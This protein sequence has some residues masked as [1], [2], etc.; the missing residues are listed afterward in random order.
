MITLHDLN[1]Q[2]GSKI[3]LEGAQLRLHD[4]HRAGLIGAN[5][6]G[7]STLFKLLTGQLAP[8]QGE[9][10]I[11][12]GWRIAHMAQEIEHSDRR[13]LDYV[14]DGDERFREVQ[15]AI[16]SCDGDGDLLARHYAD[17]EAIDGYTAEAR[18]QELLYGLGFGGGDGDRPVADF[19]GGWRI[20]LNLARALMCPA[21]LLL[22][23]EPTNHLDL[24]TTWWLEQRLKQFRG[25][26][27]VISH[28]RDFLDNTVE[29]I[30]H[31]D[32]QRL[33]LYSGSYSD[34]ERQRSER[35][36]QQQQMFEK[37]QAQIAHIERFVE[38]FRAK[39]SKAKQAQ[40][41]L[42]ALQRLET[43][44]PAHVDSPF[45]FQIP[46]SDK[47]SQPLLQLSHARLGY[48]DKAILNEVNLRIDS[49]SRF[50]LLGPNGAGKSTLM[51]A[52][53]GELAPLQ[54]ERTRGEHLAL[55]YFNQHQL[56]ALDLGAS[57]AL[58]IQRLSPGVR[59]QEV[60]NFLG[61]FGFHGDRAFEIIRHF[62][63]GEK[64][65]LAL[66]L[67][68]WQKPNVLLLDEP[69][70]HLDLEM[71][72][73]LTL[74]L[75]SYPG[76]VL[77]ISHDRHLLRNTVDEF[78]LVANGKVEE[79]NGDLEDY[80]RWMTDNH[81]STDSPASAPAT[82]EA[83]TKVDRRQQRQAAA[84]LRQQLQP[85]RKKVQAAEKR[86]EQQQQALSQL[87]EQ[88]SDQ[89]LY[90]DSK[91]AELQALLKQQGELRQTLSE[92]EEE[93][94]TLSEEYEEMEAA[95]SAE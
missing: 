51:K 68:A 37:Q 12:S 93:W 75:Q 25:T 57:P 14:L 45:Q 1:L 76:A 79:F 89:S 54:G 80:H 53:V 73:A 7:K 34:F 78:L 9:C 35:L 18:A 19:S 48:G 90:T 69:T 85:L 60:R 20:R 21:D 83:E 38:R 3:L 56:E 15:Q 5:G 92:T 91:K 82:A 70:N 32:Q 41:R 36:A 88:L 86:M 26:M 44:A 4:G 63:G 64:A 77:V 8:D 81:R 30:I 87:E 17:F 33:T 49:G 13:A 24:D 2:R 43:I 23:D 59:E 6:S 50:G 16:A 84:A 29:Q 55:G 47:T 52:L 27:L 31:L 11:P 39:A 58:H 66:A 65:R 71:R 61:G 94:M 62:S 95:L 42:K 46:C 72:E 10:Q 74:A 67:I 40:S 28:D 22:L